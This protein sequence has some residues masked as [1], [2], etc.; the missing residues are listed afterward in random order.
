MTSYVLRGKHQLESAA[1]FIVGLAPDRPWRL[2]VVQHRAKRSPEQNKLL[3]AIYTRMAEGTGH[4]AEEIHEAMKVK[5]LPPQ[6]IQIGDESVKVPASS[7]RLDTKQFSDFVEQVQ[8]FAATEL[9][10]AEL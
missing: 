9:G 5:F 4:T 6:F 7:S 3:W 1:T 2:E 8:M 10:I